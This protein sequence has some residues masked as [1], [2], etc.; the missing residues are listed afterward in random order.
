MA[1]S[2]RPFES[3]TVSRL[4]SGYRRLEHSAKGLFRKGRLALIWGVQ[5]VAFPAYVA[6]QSIRTGYR[7]LQSQNPWQRLQNLLGS[8]SPNVAPVT[9]DTP[10]R[11]LLSVIQPLLVPTSGRLQA[12]NC[13][14]TFLRQS[15]GGRVLTNGGWHLLPL[16]EPIRGIASDLVTRQLVLVTVGNGIFAD[17]IEDQQDR[18]ARAI[19]L[20]LAEY[21]TTLRQRQWQQQLK[22]SGLPLP[23]AE[24][25]QWLPVRWL[26]KGMRWMQTGG[27]AMVT[28]LFGESDQAKRL[29]YLQGQQPAARLWNLTQPAQSLR[30]EEPEWLSPKA[31]SSRDIVSIGNREMSP[32]PEVVPTETPAP[33]VDITTALVTTALDVAAQPTRSK[34]QTDGSAYQQTVEVEV[35]GT[36][37]IDHAFVRLLRWIDQGLY[38]LEKSARQIWHWLRQHL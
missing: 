6:V 32:V 31:F 9:A 25:A 10:I 15:Q 27:L 24:P 18:L 29:R 8:A 5:V 13:H 19:A 37:Y 12:V 33:P 26:Q 2:S 22:Q 35:S 1:S 14:G 7:R 38:W 11:A 3:Q 28:N 30:P 20:L 17:L 4:W 21:A 16:K 34:I 36:A 23:K